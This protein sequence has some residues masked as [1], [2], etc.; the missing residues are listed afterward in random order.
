MSE[1]YEAWDDTEFVCRDCGVVIVESH[2]PEHDA[3]HDRI[4][5][6]EERLEM[7]R[8]LQQQD[9]QS[10]DRLIVVLLQRDREDMEASDPAKTRITE[11]DIE[12][13]A[14]DMFG[15]GNPDTPPSAENPNKP[16]GNSGSMNRDAVF[17]PPNDA[18]LLCAVC[19]EPIRVS[20]G[21]VKHVT[22][23]AKGPYGI[24]FARMPLG[25]KTSLSGSTV[26]GSIEPEPPTSVAPAGEEHGALSCAVCGERV[27][28]IG[29]HDGTAKTAHLDTII[30]GTTFD[31]AATLTP[32]EPHVDPCDCD[33]CRAAVQPT[34]PPLGAGWF[35]DEWP[36]VLWVRFHNGWAGNPDE[37]VIMGKEWPDL[38]PGRPA[39]PGGER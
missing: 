24:H 20:N 16:Y 15:S 12:Q 9:R 36:G 4:D 10:I 33:D 26:V 21:V 35:A 2:Y 25:H 22:P 29:Q 6:L 31:H 7:T 8:Q 3:F 13:H 30:G 28:Q 27:L 17:A 5:R 39:V 38:L 34:E 11:A 19:G 14:R 18:V 37:G 1:R 23:S 32:P